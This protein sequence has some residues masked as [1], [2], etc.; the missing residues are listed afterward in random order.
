[1]SSTEVSSRAR[2]FHGAHLPLVLGVVSLVTLGAFENRAVGTALPTMVREFDALGSFGLA[3]A[4]PNAGYLVSLAVAGLWADRRGPIPALRAGAITFGLA[5]LLVGT[6]QGMPMVVAGRLLSGLAEGLLDVALMVLVARALPAVLRPRMF[7]LFAAMWIL[8]SVLGPLL[9]GVITEQFG[10]RWVF[11][12]A[13][14]LL[15]PSWLLLQPAMRQSA[16]TPAPERSPEDAAEL[17]A[18]RAALPWAFGASVALFT[19]T[20]AG[21]Q[22]EAHPLIAGLAIPISLAVLAAAAVRVMPRGTF[23]ARRGFP[24]VVAVRGLGGAAFA[25]AGAYLPLLLTLQHDFS[26]SR[27]GVT[28]SITGVSWAFG[29]WLQG[30]DHRMPRTSVLRIGL[31]LM[32]V[33]LAG[34]SLLAWTDTTTWAGLAGWTVAGIGMGLS[35]SSLSVLTLDLSDANNSGRNSSAAQM[36][37]T[38]S[39]ATALA[40]SGTLLALNAAHPTRWVFGTI[41]AASAALAL[42]GLLTSARVRPAS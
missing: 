19:M 42:A 17:V 21:D 37:S 14:A 36:A 12:G 5:Q 41:I 10:W 26:P 8:P 33:G 30:R 28:L 7:S 15:V 18:S 3:N 40:V 9:T 4:A 32:A 2:L 31:A 23:T 27:A 35:T 1:M 11:L 22:L 13:L 16:S 25:G 29:S 20:L 39:I 34:T 38:M 6:A 24:A